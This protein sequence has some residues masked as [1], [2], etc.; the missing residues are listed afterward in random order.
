NLEVSGKNNA[1]VD[2]A[3]FDKYIKPMLVNPTFV[4]DFPAYMCPLTKDKRG[5]S[6]LSERFELYI[7]GY[8][9]MNC[10]S[11]LTDPVEQRRKFDE[12]ERERQRGD[13]EAPP[14]DE[15]FLEA[16]EFGMPP[17]AGIGMAIDRLS[18]IFTDNVS[19]KEVIA[20]PAVRPEKKAPSG[21]GRKRKMG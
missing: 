4:A 9:T 18:M 2:D 6:R 13:E 11:E 14:S 17:T 1:H 15:D 21:A 20:F 5:N 16:V 7:A 3:L 8:E 19:L 10:Y 12:Q